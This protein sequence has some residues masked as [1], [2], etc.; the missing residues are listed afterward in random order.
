[1]EQLSDIRLILVERHALHSRSQEMAVQRYWHPAVWSAV[2]YLF[3]YGAMHNSETL[4]RTFRNMVLVAKPRCV[5]VPAAL[6][7]L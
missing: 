6:K 4:H 5:S 2:H 3:V 7:G 1:M